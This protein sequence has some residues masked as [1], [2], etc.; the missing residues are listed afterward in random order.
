MLLNVGDYVISED[1]LLS[2]MQ[3]NRTQGIRGEVFFFYEGLRKMNDLL[4]K[5]IY[6]NFYSEP[7]ELPFVPRFKHMSQDV[8]KIKN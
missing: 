1:F 3:Y 6:T 7:A 8:Q 4:A 5:S 2:S